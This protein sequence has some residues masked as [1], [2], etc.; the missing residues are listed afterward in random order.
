MVCQS[1][2][3]FK[4]FYIQPCKG[5]PC[6]ARAKNEISYCPMCMKSDIS[7]TVLHNPVE[8]GAK[9]HTLLIFGSILYRIGG[10]W[11]MKCQIFKCT[12]DRK[13]HFL[14]FDVYSDSMS[15]KQRKYLILL[16]AIK[17]NFQLHTMS[18]MAM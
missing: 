12:Q 3:S 14:T 18:S 2:H 1:G 5:T 15:L 8:D 17:V 4:Y 9:C 11:S 13:V 6:H 7:L 10:K 16:T